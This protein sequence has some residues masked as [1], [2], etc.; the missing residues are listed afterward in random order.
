MMRHD[1]ERVLRAAQGAGR[2][3][4]VGAPPKAMERLLKFT[5]ERIHAAR[6]KEARRLLER[7]LRAL[8]RALPD[9]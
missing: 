6:T 4:V 7:A 2:E 3:V 8:R 5:R 1:L 9:A